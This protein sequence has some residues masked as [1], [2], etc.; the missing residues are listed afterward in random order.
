VPKPATFECG[1]TLALW[2]CQ[3]VKSRDVLITA[4]QWLGRS[5]ARRVAVIAAS[6]TAKLSAV[7]TQHSS[8]LHEY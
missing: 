4:A 6:E 7:G 3:H 8:V 2:P 1:A 5:H